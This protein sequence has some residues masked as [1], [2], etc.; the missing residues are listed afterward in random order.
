MNHPLRRYFYL[1]IS[2]LMCVAIS[3][4]FLRPY[5]FPVTQGN[6]ICADT[7]AQLQVGMSAN[8]VRYLMGTPMLQDVF[9]ENRWDYIYIEKPG[10]GPAARYHLAIFF[11]DG[12]IASIMQ[13]PL[14]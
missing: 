1:V 14:S 10:Y 2:V 3:G 7:V 11:Q 4:C 12:H 6:E 5:R 9:H 13:D 8:E